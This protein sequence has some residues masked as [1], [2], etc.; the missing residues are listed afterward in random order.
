MK[1]I[2]LI[3]LVCLAVAG[4]ASAQ[5]APLHAEAPA[6]VLN[7]Y[8]QAL[9]APEGALLQFLLVNGQAHPPT[10]NGAPHT[11]NT[12]VFTTRIGHGVS[13]DPAML[14]RFS[15]AI[16]PRPAGA[17]F[18]RVFNAPTLEGAS[19]YTDSQAFTPPQARVVFYPILNATTNALDTA[20]DDG[21]GV[22]NSWEKSLGSDKNSGD[23]DGDGVPDGH[24]F[25]AGTKLNDASSFLALVRLT[26]QPGGHLRAE[27][28]SVP[29]KSYQ[30][31][32]ASLDFAQSGSIFS[33]VNTVV[34]ASGVEAASVITNGAAIPMGIFR[35][36]LAED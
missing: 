16:T 13:S 8:G 36:R 29:G 35:V 24:E 32:H 11:S 7:E 21:D 10:V 20:D 33:N 23:S 19:F 1:T 12:V 31:E 27:W 26:T 17:I 18:A 14:G 3:S 25:R 5:Q 30:L 2:R 28:G 34:T 15:A 6:P 4:V 9:S 22:H